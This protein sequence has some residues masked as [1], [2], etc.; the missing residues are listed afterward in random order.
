MK[1]R[2]NNEIKDYRTIWLS[3]KIVKM[4]NQR[5]LPHEFRIYEARNHKQTAQAIMNMVVR[6]AGAIGV[7]G[8]FGIAQ[9]ALEVQ[10]EELSE[11]S[12]YVEKAAVLFKSTRPTGVNLFHAI[13][14][15]ISV[16]KTGS[17]V[18]ECKKL[19]VQEAQK[20][21]NEDMEASR[22]IGEYG[23]DLI[24]DGCGILTHCN[25]GALAFT[26]HGTALS[27]IRFAHYEGK[28]P[29]VFIDETRPMCQ[30]S[31]LTAW[32]LY[33][34]GIEHAVIADNAAGFFMR[35]GG[36]QMVL[37]GADRI[38]ANGDIANKIGTYEKAVL[39]KENHIPFYVAAPLIT[40]DP[41]CE[42][43]DRIPIEERPTDE[44]LCMWG[45]NNNGRFTK[46]RIAPISS[47][48]RNPAFDITPAQY[49]HGIITERGIVAPPF[50]E[51]IQ[52]LFKAVNIKIAGTNG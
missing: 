17:N 6:G 3:G 27:P 43:G 32:E 37:V 13:D 21:A 47:K 15:C 22:K 19:A 24:K 49:I 45:V 25:A 11:F 33:Q 40:F 50:K 16:M 12:E 30:G 42:S 2:V 7:A 34:E 38:A 48:A 20:I 14:R 5:L 39:A 10:S 51:N 4:I 29:F 35:K 31:R 28:N 36:I 52:K 44:V 18:E 41:K 26:D 1:V 9:A 8:A 23:K 46:I